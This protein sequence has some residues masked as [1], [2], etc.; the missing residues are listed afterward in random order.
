MI[1]VLIFLFI[2]NMFLVACS[3]ILIEDS[4]DVTIDTLTDND[5]APK[6]SL[7]DNSR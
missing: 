5:T 2:V 3:V 6:F 1:R 4:E 7:P